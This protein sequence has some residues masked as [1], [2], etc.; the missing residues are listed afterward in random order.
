MYYSDVP[1]SLYTLIPQS[2]LFRLII[3]SKLP[4]AEKFESWIMEDLL[5][6]VTNTGEYQLNRAEREEETVP[7][8]Q[9]LENPPRIPFIRQSI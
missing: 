6:Q 7:I 9:W 2:D 1:N 4:T 5:P 3:K 8:D